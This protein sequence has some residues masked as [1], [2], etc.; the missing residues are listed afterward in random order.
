M[1]RPGGRMWDLT[2]AARVLPQ[3]GAP[4]VYR[5]RDTRP[6]RRRPAGCHIPNRIIIRARAPPV[7]EFPPPAGEGA[8]L[9]RGDR[10]RAALHGGSINIEPGGDDDRLPRRFCRRAERGRRSGAGRKRAKGKE[11]ARHAP[12]LPISGAPH[13]PAPAAPPGPPARWSSD[14][15]SCPAAPG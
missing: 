1:C 6:P 10:G 15:A 2:G 12:F 13:S 7:K 14:T 9:S 3:S 4:Q 11:R 5:L 8:A